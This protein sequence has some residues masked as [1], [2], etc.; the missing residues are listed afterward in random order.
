MATRDFSW[1]PGRR[2]RYAFLLLPVII[3]VAVHDAPHRFS[4]KKAPWG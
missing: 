2:G 4:S 3:G 1:H